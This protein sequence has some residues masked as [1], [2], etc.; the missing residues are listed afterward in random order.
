VGGINIHRTHIPESSL[1][2]GVLVQTTFEY[3]EKI[4]HITRMRVFVVDNNVVGS[5]ISDDL[6]IFC[7]LYLTKLVTDEL[8]LL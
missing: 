1:G 4:P 3:E 2:P 6:D 8:D 5:D 7:H